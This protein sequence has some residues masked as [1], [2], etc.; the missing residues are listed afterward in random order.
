MSES[1]YDYILR[2]FS[3]PLL[4]VTAALVL[5]GIR[6]R[7]MSERMNLV[8]SL[9]NLEEATSVVVDGYNSLKDSKEHLETRLSE[10]RCSLVSVYN[11]AMSL[12][13]LD[14]ASVMATAEKLIRS[15]LKPA[16]FS[17]FRISDG[18]LR[19]KAAYG[20]TEDDRYTERFD[21]HSSYR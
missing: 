14:N 2:A 13:T 7:Q 17:I 6:E 21:T 5:G 11:I 9:H 19:L 3:Q 12:E 15:A 1:S 8:E 10:E 20:W 16:K 4:W 18:M